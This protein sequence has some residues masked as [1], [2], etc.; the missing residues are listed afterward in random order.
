VAFPFRDT[1]ADAV[2]TDERQVSRLINNL[3]KRGHLSMKIRGRG[4]SN[5]YQMILKSGTPMSPIPDGKED[6]DVRHSPKSRTSVTEKEDICDRKGGHGCPVHIE[7]SEEHDEEHTEERV[8]P[9]ILPADK[10]AAKNR[11]RDRGSCPD[12]SAAFEEFWRCYPKRAGK[13]AARRAYEKII[14][15]GSATVA[16]LLAGAKRYTAERAGQDQKYTKHPSGWLND[17]RWRDDAGVDGSAPVIDQ[18]GNPIEQ[19]K[20]APR[21]G[22]VDH[23]AAAGFP[24]GWRP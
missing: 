17:G 13:D 8:S 18:D 3:V 7:H 19:P 2:G 6:T 22:G 21:G 5:T 16:E 23:M 15:N 12:T 24:K 11:N 20:A 9:E 4:R 14:R 1:I 10:P